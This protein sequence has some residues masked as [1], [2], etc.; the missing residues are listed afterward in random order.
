MVSLQPIL[1]KK[2]NVLLKYKTRPSIQSL[3]NYREARANVQRAEYDRARVNT[4][5]THERKTV[6]QRQQLSKKSEQ[7]ERWF[8]HYNELYGT[9]GSSDIESI[10]TLCSSPQMSHLDSAPG[11][12]EIIYTLE[13]HEV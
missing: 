9:E 2:R 1:E 5:T 7:L 4:G 10:S 6:D 13:R 11:I 8:E 3:D 12:E